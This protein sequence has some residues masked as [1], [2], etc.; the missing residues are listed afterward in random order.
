MWTIATKPYKDAHF[1]TFPPKLVIPC[2]KAGTRPG[3]IVLDPFAGSGTTGAVCVELGRDFI[4]ID[5][6]SKY[7]TLARRRIADAR[8]IAG[9][10]LPSSK[11]KAVQPA[12]PR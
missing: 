8:K 7:L 5:L 2:I 11:T 1:A 9:P 4:G 10:Q 6:N 3:G 12:S